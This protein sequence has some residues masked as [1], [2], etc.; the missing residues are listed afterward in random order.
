MI[1]LLRSSGSLKLSARRYSACSCQKM[2]TW[3]SRIYRYQ[4]EAHT[5]NITHSIQEFL[6]GQ[7]RLLHNR[8]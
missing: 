1:P 3:I 4:F 2:Y 6:Y 8:T 7:S 5:E